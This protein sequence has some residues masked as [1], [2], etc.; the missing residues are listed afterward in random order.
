MWH[1]SS[2]NGVATLRTAVHLL[3]TYL[4]CDIRLRPRPGAAPGASVRTAEWLLAGVR[5]RCD[6]AR[7]L[8]SG[9]AATAGSVVWSADVRRV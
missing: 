6:P 9:S 7:F 4:H 2:R 8:G 1:V 5:D 3:L